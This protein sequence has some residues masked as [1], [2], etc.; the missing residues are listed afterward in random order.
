MAL[1]RL[2]RAGR[3]PAPPRR[4]LF[5]YTPNGVHL[6]AWDPEG[7]ATSEPTAGVLPEELPPILSELERHRGHWSLLSGLCLDKARANGDGGGDHARAMAA[8]LTCAQPYKGDGSRLEVGVSV[9]QLLAPALRGDS[10]FSS[11]QL[12]GEGAVTAG[13]CDTG[14]PCVYSSHLSWSGPRTPLAPESS[15][16]RLFD[17]LFGRGLEGLNEEARRRRLRRRRSIL[18][19]VRREARAEEAAAGRSDRHKLEEF[20]DAL[21]DLELRLLDDPVASGASLARP[22]DPIDLETRLELLV[23]LL[24]LAIASDQTRTVSFALA[25]EGSSHVYRGLGAEGG[26]HQI[27]HHAGD[28]ELIEQVVRI[29]RFHAALLA[30]LLDRLREIPE[31]DGS[32]LDHTL[33]AYGSGNADGYTHAHHDLPIVLAG[34]GA[35][36]GR[37]GWLRYPPETPLANLH[38]SL[39]GA[40]GAPVPEVGFG[41]GTGTLELLEG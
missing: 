6:P 31:G 14:Y 30:R 22:E 17:R 37:A 2:G 35:F 27:T 20:Q 9:D 11:L 15:P 33:V 25:N 13:Q 5:L 7:V 41:D 21:R 4:A 29:N 34:G 39:L 28:P 12:S 40:L 36:P 32:L 18:D 38:T 16:A 26:H 1:S 23:E 24:V 19:F 3:P 8:F 10:P